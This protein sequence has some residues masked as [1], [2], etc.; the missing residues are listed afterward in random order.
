MSNNSIISPPLVKAATG[1]TID[2][3]E[4]GI[5]AQPQYEE[6][7]NSRLSQKE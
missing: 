6:P 1:S 3:N 5:E 7:I 4:K 2:H